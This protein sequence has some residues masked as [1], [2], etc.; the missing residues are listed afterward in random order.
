MMMFDQFVMILERTKFGENVLGVL[1][2]PILN[3]LEL[4]EETVLI[5]ATNVI[6][7]LIDITLQS[8][9]YSVVNR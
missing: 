2:G 6:Q 9:R 5:P 1:Y 3:A 8:D 4:N 7:I